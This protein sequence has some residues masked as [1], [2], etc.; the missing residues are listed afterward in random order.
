MVPRCHWL[1]FN[2]ISTKPIASERDRGEPQPREI[3]RC[4]SASDTDSLPLDMGFKSWGWGVRTRLG[5]MAAAA[6][7]QGSV[8]RRPTFASPTSLQPNIAADSTIIDT[9]RRF[10]SC[11]ALAGRIHPLYSYTKSLL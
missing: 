11:Y 4:H 7:L 3:F 9:R 5:V 6:S 10:D 2:C 1:L 8:V